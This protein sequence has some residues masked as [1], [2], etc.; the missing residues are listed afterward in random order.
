VLAVETTVRWP[1]HPTRV[2]RH[3]VRYF[4][5]SLPAT[6]PPAALLRLVRTHWHIENRLHGPRDVTL[7]DDACRVRV[8]RAPQAL[9]AVRNAVRGLLHGHATTTCAAA[10]RACAWLP[11][12]RLLSLLGLSSP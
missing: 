10:I 9:A 6:T 5:S 2:P 7:G 1:A 3:D 4:L 8:G 11:P 12:P